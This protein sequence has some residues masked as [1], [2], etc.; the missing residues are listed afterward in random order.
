MSNVR[1]SAGSRAHP[2]PTSGLALQSRL[3]DAWRS[4]GAAASDLPKDLA[5]LAAR[6]VD[7]VPSADC[8]RLASRA[9]RGSYEILAGV[10]GGIRLGG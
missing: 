9:F 2:A 8:V 4:C 10:E 3:G 7:R 6:G 5:N 1:S